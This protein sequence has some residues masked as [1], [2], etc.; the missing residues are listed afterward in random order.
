MEEPRFSAG[1]WVFGG[2]ADR[3]CREG[4]SEPLPLEKQIEA[5]GQVHGIS[6]IECHQSDFER[7][8]AQRF[9]QLLDDNG[10]TCSNVNTDVWTSRRWKWGAYTI[11]D[12]KLRREAI[13][14]GKRAVDVAREVGA[15]GIGQWLGADGFDYPFQIDYTEQ[16]K[17]IIEGLRQV[18]DY[19]APD[20]RVG[21]EYKLKEPRTHMTIGS[22][23]KALAVMM[24]LDMDNV[25]GVIDFGHALM[26]GENPAESVAILARQGK[27]FN[28]HF[29]DAYGYWDDTRHSPSLGDAGVP[30]LLPQDRLPGLFR[31]GYVPLPGGWP[32][33][34]RDGGAEP[35]RPMEASGQA[36]CSSANCGPEDDGRYR[37]PG[38]G[39]QSCVHPDGN[40]ALNRDVWLDGPPIEG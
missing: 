39:A 2:C 36:R 26:S 17:L 8:S 24:E 6:A 25:G 4:Y 38:G 18:A 40:G 11:R 7:I 23:G 30:I 28:I 1:L 34:R 27:L 22:V 14:Q 16:W 12:P 13:E 21:I 29:N 9:R 5:A 31:P 15:P 32:T 20:I 33:R 19:A 35:H 10:L 37:H 3:F